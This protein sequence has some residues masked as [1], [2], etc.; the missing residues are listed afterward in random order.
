VCTRAT[1]DLVRIVLRDSAHIQEE[2]AA[3]KA[4]RHRKEGRRGKHPE[5]P[6]YTAEDVDRTLP[7]L[8]P[9]PYNETTEIKD[10]VRVTFHDAGHIL[11]SAIVDFLVSQHG[12]TRRILFSGDLGRWEKPLL[13]DPTLFTQADY[14]VMESTYG[15]RDH[16]DTKAVEE[17]LTPIFSQTLRAGGNVVIPTFAVE[18]AQE[19]MFY[20][21]RLVR[22]DRIPDVPVFLNSPMAVDVTE[23]FRRHRDCLDAETWALINSGEPPLRFPGL[24][25][26]RSVEESKQIHELKEPAI[27]MATSGMCTAGRIKHH[28]RHNISRPE[29]TIL[30]VGYQ[31]YGTLGR[32]ILEGEP[33]VRIHGRKWPVRAKVAQIQ[34]MS[35]HAGRTDF[36]RWLAAFGEPPRHV[37]LV[38]GEE[39]SSLSL[40]GQIQDR[41]RW[42]V[43]VPEYLDQS[44]LA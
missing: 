3:Y 21:S 4:K 29:S 34:G 35:G 39:D 38:H 5:I 37:I 2:D 14:V 7:H 36:M 11:G 17:Q 26:V 31:A 20:I 28:L 24:K 33:E 1:A 41:F 16:E 30:F 8:E 13:R 10:G 19:L 43:T 25:L 22:T 23:L 6:L 40:A 42:Q 15:N 18:R 44:K 27:I 9:R 12:E 32:R